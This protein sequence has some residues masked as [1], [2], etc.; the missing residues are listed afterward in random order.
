MIHV[1]K[2]LRVL[3]RQNWR[4]GEDKDIDYYLISLSI[5]TMNDNIYEKNHVLRIYGAVT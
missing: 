3:L 2:K 5:R 4:G 1:H